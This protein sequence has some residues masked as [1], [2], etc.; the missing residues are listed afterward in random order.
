MSAGIINSSRSTDSS[1]VKAG[2]NFLA[3]IDREF[4]ADVAANDN[5]NGAPP[6]LNHRHSDVCD[7]E[8]LENVYI[9]SINA[10]SATATVDAMS[11]EGVEHSDSSD[12]H[13]LCERMNQSAA[14]A[15]AKHTNAN[16]YADHTVYD[17]DGD[18]Q[19]YQDDGS[20]SDERLQQEARPQPQHATPHLAMT[21]ILDAAGASQSLLSTSQHS[22]SQQSQQMGG[23]LQQHQKKHEN[24][25]KK[26]LR[27]RATKYF[28]GASS[29][30]V[31]ETAVASAAAAAAVVVDTSKNCDGATNHVA[32][33]D[34]GRKPD[35]ETIQNDATIATG[36]SNDGSSISPT[37]VVPNV[38]HPPPSIPNRHNR[39]ITAANNNV[40]TSKGANNTTSGQPRKK[41]TAM[42]FFPRTAVVSPLES[43]L[44]Q[45]HHVQRQQKYSGQ[46]P[47]QPQS[48]QPQLDII[49]PTTSSTLSNSRPTSP[50]HQPPFTYSDPPLQYASDSDV[51]SD[52]GSGYGS[53]YGSAS[54]DLENAA[55]RIL[56]GRKRFGGNSGVGGVRSS[57][58]VTADV[59]VGGG[60]G[61]ADGERRC[62][63]ASP[64]TTMTGAPGTSD[65]ETTKN[66]NIAQPTI[67]TT[68]RAGNTEAAAT[69]PKSSATTAS[70]IAERVVNS[71]NN[72]TAPDATTSK[73]AKPNASNSK[74]RATLPPAWKSRPS[75]ER[76][77]KKTGRACFANNNLG[78][79]SGYGNTTTA[80]T[81]DDDEEENTVSTSVEGE[82]L[83]VLQPLP[84]SMRY[85]ND[86]VVGG[87]GGYANEHEYDQHRQQQ[88]QYYHDST[89]N[90]GYYDQD[91]HY[92][93]PCESGRYTPDHLNTSDESSEYYPE[94][95]WDED[96]GAFPS[97]NHRYSYDGHDANV[98]VATR[99]DEYHED[100]IPSG[101]GSEEWGGDP[102][103][104]FMPVA[105]NPGIDHVYNDHDGGDGV[106]Q[107]VYQQPNY[108]MSDPRPPHASNNG[109]TYWNEPKR[110]HSS[111]SLE[112]D[113]G[114]AGGDGNGF[115]NNDYFHQFYLKSEQTIQDGS[116]WEEVPPAPGVEFSP[117]RVRKAGS[118]S[119]TKDVQ[120]GKAKVW[121]E[122]TIAIDFFTWND[123]EEYPHDNKQSDWT[124]GGAKAPRAKPALSAQQQGMMSV[125]DLSLN[126]TL[127][128]SREDEKPLLRLGEGKPHTPPNQPPQ[129]VYPFSDGEQTKE[130]QGLSPSR[131][132]RRG[133]T[134]FRS[135]ERSS[136]RSKNYH[137]EGERSDSDWEE[138]GSKSSFGL[139]QLRWKGRR[140][141]QTDSNKRS[142]RGLK[143]FGERRHGKVIKT[144][145][146]SPSIMSYELIRKES[147]GL[148]NKGGS[149]VIQQNAT[150]IRAE[151]P[152]SKI[153]NTPTKTAGSASRA[154]A[155]S[156]TPSTM[157]RLNTSIASLNDSQITQSTPLAS[158][159]TKGP[160]K[161]LVHSASMKSPRSAGLPP[162]PAKKGS[163][164][165]NGNEKYINQYHAQSPQEPNTDYDG[166]EDEEE[167]SVST[168]DS[169]GSLVTKDNRSKSS[170]SRQRP[171][172][173]DLSTVSGMS[174]I[175]RLRR[176][177]EKLREELE[178]ASHISSKLSS[179][180]NKSLK[181]QNERL[182]QSLED[183]SQLS[184]KLSSLQNTKSTATDSRNDHDMMYK[185][186]IEALLAKD[187]K[188]R[189][190]KSR[191]GG[192]GVQPSQHHTNCY[193]MAPL[194]NG[195]D[196]DD[197]SITTYSAL[198]SGKKVQFI[199]DA[200][201]DVRGAPE[202]LKR[203][204][205]TTR[206]VAA[207]IKTTATEM[208]TDENRERLAYEASKQYEYFTACTRKN[209]RDQDGI[210]GPT[211]T[212]ASTLGSS[213]GRAMGCVK[214]GVDKGGVSASASSQSTGTGSVSDTLVHR[215][216]GLDV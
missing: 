23:I 104:D 60:S 17:E 69:K 117:I 199:R 122:E 142:Q 14:A 163:P 73:S 178:N 22:N 150:P 129:H 52:L 55:R 207:R 31:A 29:N 34:D 144:E 182:R 184:S 166:D 102:Y 44:D 85:Y 58:P 143:L 162:L 214:P 157:S 95:G 43:P 41:N 197:D 57:S 140:K 192:T 90:N 186:T 75:R 211:T 119:V 188:R 194:I 11:T 138:S 127:D 202:L 72:A 47:Q 121:K 206:T 134:L 149:G 183:S 101:S 18:V 103:S 79:G 115:N 130:E 84:P 175:E 185:S 116:C 161:P 13:Q 19:V 137:S 193:P 98:V 153:D 53:G 92:Y 155:G 77:Q 181:H 131:R 66:N 147:S 124:E 111:S 91:G 132:S 67:I 49:S 54:S 216:D 118:A 133:L 32:E 213:I 42:T 71:W 128:L 156:P 70:S 1:G 107:K 12:V 106:H 64:L 5:D 169:L 36:T 80:T 39:N 46:Q 145:E 27:L 45:S 191:R 63:S 187:D 205:T 59:T 177:N 89:A 108:N 172:E 4:S 201:C 100:I 62:S 105:P 159:K 215:R 203:I 8:E 190:R 40:A 9:G 180:Y 6:D 30:K 28:R 38:A 148:S 7:Y 65:G 152:R 97:T 51:A 173:S 61:A 48:N 82:D 16:Q 56:R 76:I 93:P 123:E 15:A 24:S 160:T 212:C 158:N 200:N 78:R 151:Q 208:N 170:R 139:T 20:G 141:S 146:D 110:V 113:A 37:Q 33:N 74:A 99:E 174:E 154:G 135:R 167:Q 125:V 96:V 204:A 164:T 94:N 189:R 87:D 86:G 109:S 210:S 2:M 209:N 195:A 88:H 165:S 10:T 25:T 168:S 126:D 120:R 112:G 171:F 35:G 50:P 81:D 114:S 136:S 3:R 26:A 21:S 196:F 68:F 176:E 179:M 83:D 198:D